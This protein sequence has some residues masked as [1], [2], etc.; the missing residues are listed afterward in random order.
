MFICIATPRL[1]EFGMQ[2]VGER[3]NVYCI[4]F[5]AFLLLI[6]MESRKALAWERF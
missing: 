5:N 2:Y 3:F 6:S 4:V 1:Y